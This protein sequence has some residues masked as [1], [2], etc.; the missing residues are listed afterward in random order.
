MVYRATILCIHVNV[1]TLV[2]QLVISPMVSL[3]LHHGNKSEMN[4]LIFPKKILFIFAPWLQKSL[5]VKTC[6]TAGIQMAYDH[7]QICSFLPSAISMLQNHPR[8][9]IINHFY[10]GHIIVPWMDYCLCV[11]MLNGPKGQQCNRRIN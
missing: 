10:P 7:L 4:M 9:S 1:P 5:S 2:H 11:Y 3:V 6:S 8:V